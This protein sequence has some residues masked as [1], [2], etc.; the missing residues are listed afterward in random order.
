MLVRRRT[1]QHAATALEARCQEL[2]ETIARAQAELNEIRTLHATVMSTT[3][4]FPNI[5]SI[6]L[7]GCHNLTNAA[8]KV[9]AARCPQLQSLNVECVASLDARARAR[10]T[11]LV[12]SGNAAS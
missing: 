5:K 6:D 4:Q 9:L 1:R 2:E 11:R 10:L 8:I 3:R 12:V 7:S